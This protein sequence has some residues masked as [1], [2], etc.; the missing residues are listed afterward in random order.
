MWVTIGT[1]CP[2]LADTVLVPLAFDRDDDDD[3]DIIHGKTLAMRS[4]PRQSKGKKE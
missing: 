3:D 2:Y 1:P 4:K